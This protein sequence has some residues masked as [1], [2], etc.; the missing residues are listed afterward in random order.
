MHVAN[1][2]L[3]D[4]FNNGWEKVQKGQFIVIVRSL[5]Q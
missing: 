2:Q 4:T 1:I 3:P 5:R